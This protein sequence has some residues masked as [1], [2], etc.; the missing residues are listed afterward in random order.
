MFST[1]V[2][3]MAVQLNFN[4]S[5]IHGCVRLTWM[6]FMTCKAI[7]KKL[8]NPKPHWVIIS[9][10][11]DGQSKTKQ[12]PRILFAILRVGWAVLLV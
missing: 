5:K 11:P 12:N 8:Q 1:P 7:V 9:Q 4:F 3:V 10:I 2:V 6:T